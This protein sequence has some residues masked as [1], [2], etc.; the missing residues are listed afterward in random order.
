MMMETEI[1]SDSA[2]DGE[3]PRKDEGGDAKRVDQV[4]ET[5]DVKHGDGD[6]GKDTVG[7]GATGGNVV[8]SK[9]GAE[10]VDG[11]QAGNE[12]VK[13]EGQ[14]IDEWLLL[15]TDGARTPVRIRID[16]KHLYQRTAEGVGE[17]K[18]DSNVGAE[19]AEAV[20]DKENKTDTNG[21]AACGCARRKRWACGTIKM[22]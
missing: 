12:E 2:S 22:V 13:D 21:G 9:A 8:E 15:L 3:V 19:A 7:G 18:I 1:S 4:D 17:V 14:E 10:V 16:G 6:A 20:E 11:A 5:S